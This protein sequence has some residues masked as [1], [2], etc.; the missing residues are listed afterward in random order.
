MPS[1][2]RV[3]VDIPY[4]LDGVSGLSWAGAGLVLDA[5]A[6]LVLVDRN[7]V[8]V[9]HGPRPLKNNNNQTQR[10]QKNTENI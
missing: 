2:V 7:T 4:Q 1:L 9:Q 6:G 5:R 10:K 3:L 8:H